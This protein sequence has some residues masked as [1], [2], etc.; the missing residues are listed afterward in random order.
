MTKKPLKNEKSMGETF[1]YPANKPWG[2][3]EPSGYKQVVLG[4]IFLKFVSYKR[5]ALRQKLE[6]LLLYRIAKNF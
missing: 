2:T 3:A 4:L 5:V 6:S 1:W